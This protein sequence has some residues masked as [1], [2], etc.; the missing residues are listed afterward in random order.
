MPTD[1]EIFGYPFTIRPET[2]QEY[3]T[4]SGAGPGR[5]FASGV[6]PATASERAEAGVARRYRIDCDF[7]EHDVKF[8][9]SASIVVTRDT[10]PDRQ[11]AAE[12]VGPAIE[13]R[14]ARFSGPAQYQPTILRLDVIELRD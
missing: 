9:S 3:G 2:A 8:G 7:V 10:P 14:I 11:Q 4:R 1:D 6:R 12:L 13:A 5:V